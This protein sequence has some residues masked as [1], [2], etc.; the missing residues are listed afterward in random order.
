M[1]EI[2]LYQLNADYSAIERRILISEIEYR[3][4]YPWRRI[5]GSKRRSISTVFLSL[6]GEFETALVAP[7][8]TKIIK[9]DYCYVEANKTHDLCCR[10]Y[11]KL[12]R[13][14]R[15]PKFPTKRK[16]ISTGTPARVV[17]ARPTRKI[18]T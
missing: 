18:R 9:R 17:T 4:M 13:K 11:L 1:A 7:S 8:F 5:T 6:E 14:K 10:E 2:K 3:H 12:L 16:S 15:P